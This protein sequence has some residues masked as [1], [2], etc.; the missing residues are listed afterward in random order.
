MGQGGWGTYRP[1]PVLMAH[2]VTLKVKW[3]IYI[4]IKLKEFIASL[5]DICPEVF[6]LI[7]FI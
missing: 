7:I 2:G 3:F 6:S 5:S 1:A 4:Y